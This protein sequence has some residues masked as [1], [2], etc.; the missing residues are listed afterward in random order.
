[1]GSPRPRWGR[2]LA[3]LGGR[4]RRS[5]GSVDWILSA[6]PGWAPAY[7]ALW[8]LILLSDALSEPTLPAV[9]GVSL[10]V[11]AILSVHAI[12]QRWRGGFSKHDGAYL[13][14]MLLGAV[15]S[16]LD[17]A[18]TPLFAAAWIAGT[19][20]LDRRTRDAPA[21]TRCVAMI[22]VVGAVLS[23]SPWLWNAVNRLAVSLTTALFSWAGGG[24]LGASASGLSA[25]LLVSPCLVW[26]AV[27]GQRHRFVP[28]V[29]AIALFLVHAGSSSL[30]GFSPRHRLAVELVY[31]ALL[32]LLCVGVVRGQRRFAGVRRPRWWAVVPAL[33]FLF[34]FACGMSW[35]PEL[36]PGRR[37]AEPRIVLFVDHSLLGSW[38]TPADAAPGAAFSGANFGQ[39]PEY[40]GAAG[41]R[42][43][44]GYE[45]DEERIDDVD[46][47]V[48][49]NPGAPFSEEEKETLYAFVKSGGGLLVLGDHTNM[50]GIMDAVN[51]LTAPLGLSLAFD[52][53]VSLDPGWSR[54]LCVLPPFSERFRPIDVPVSIGASVD[55]AVHPAVAPF[56]VGRRAFSDPGVAENIERAL[57]GNLAFDRG[58]RYGDVVLAAVRYLGR[59]KVALFGD[60]SV[61][62]SS[63]LILSYEFTDGLIRWLTDGTGAWRAPFAGVLALLLLFGSALLLDRPDALVSGVVAIVFTAGVLCGTTIAVSPKD[64]GP[65]TGPTALIDAGHGN[66]IRWDPLHTS[67]VEGLGVNLA[68][69]GFL[70]FVHHKGLVGSLPSPQSVVVSVAPTRSYS[71]R[72]IRD[73]LEWVEDGGGL[74]VTTGWPQSTALAPFLADIGISVSPVPLGAVRP[75]VVSLDVQ[76]QLPSA[77]PLETSP[78]WAPL[79][80]VEWDDAR[81]TV[82]A[83]RSIGLGRIVVVGDNG[84]FLNENLE[85]KDYA[86][87]EN[88]ALL[89]TLLSRPRGVEDPS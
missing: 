6:V 2:R 45:I 82:I 22:G 19:V 65:M 70:P 25:L 15:G 75:D 31:V 1:M 4:V 57:L 21:L 63:A 13:V 64:V 34:V 60:T 26:A 59:G 77:W 67:G 51:G 24:G 37:Y 79:G 36:A 50:G 39:F 55:A 46:L 29:T 83:E 69:N 76:P 28:V 71:Q 84:V 88:T 10:V 9:R 12:G 17:T 48:I 74:I 42:V 14:L 23:R 52:S 73:L 11:L 80:S 56:L 33:V 43:V 41:H 62:Q 20:G 78:E 49:I 38:S 58:E 16:F 8:C 81:Y 3:R 68:R 40:A 89:S 44:T 7:L 66:L 61:F 86:Y 32:L 54:A 27:R 47:V 35:L 53:A 5:L 72:E 30:F 87:V 85:G 18:A